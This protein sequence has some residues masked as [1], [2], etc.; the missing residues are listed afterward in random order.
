M[1]AIKVFLIIECLLS[2]IVAI[3]AIYTNYIFV[4]FIFVFISYGYYNGYK[5]FQRK[6]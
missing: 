4:A 1:K 6:Y 2:L 3:A 5:H